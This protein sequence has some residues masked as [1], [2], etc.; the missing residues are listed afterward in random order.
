M[1]TVTVTEAEFRAKLEAFRKRDNRLLGDY[2]IEV[3]EKAVKM[4]ESNACMRRI[5]AMPT[6]GSCGVIRSIS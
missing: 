1:A 5:V 2:L 4:G 3:M 6:A